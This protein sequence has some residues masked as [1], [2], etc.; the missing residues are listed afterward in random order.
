M[1]ALVAWLRPEDHP[2]FVLLPQN[3]YRRLR[4]A[5]DLP[6]LGKVE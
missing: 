6:D 5:W 1:Q 3:E 4:V 2:V